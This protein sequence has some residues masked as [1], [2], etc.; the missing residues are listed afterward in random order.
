MREELAPGD[1]RL[2]H[3]DRTLWAA[4]AAA[5]VGQRLHRLPKGLDTLLD[6]SLADLGQ[7]GELSGGEW[8]KLAIARALARDAQV[9][10]WMSRPQRSTPRRRWPCTAALPPSPAGA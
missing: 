8:Q 2:Q 1:P 3:D 4:A 9:L 10:F 7:G 6:P 5:G